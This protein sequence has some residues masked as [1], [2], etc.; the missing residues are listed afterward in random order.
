MQV[1]YTADGTVNPALGAQ[2]GWPGCRAAALKREQDGSLTVLPACHGVTLVPGEQVVS[3]SA[4]GGGYGAPTEREPERV[5]DDVLEGWISKE[6]AR[7]V[8]GV[9]IEAQGAS[10]TIDRAATAALR[11][12]Q[13]AMEERR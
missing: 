12:G 6:R 3:R 11:A 5:L 10:M 13:R 7:S 8:Y 1:L 9:A 4:G 2:G